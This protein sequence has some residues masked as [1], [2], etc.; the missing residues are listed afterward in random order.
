MTFVENDNALLGD[1]YFK[2]GGRVNWDWPLGNID[3][4]INISAT[5]QSSDNLY[6]NIGIYQT[7]CISYRTIYKY[8]NFRGDKYTF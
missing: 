1:S 2:M 4:P 5:S 6:I 7:F 8:F 3:L